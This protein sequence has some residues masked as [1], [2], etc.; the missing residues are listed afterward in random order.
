M[1]ITKH[2]AI[3]HLCYKIAYYKSVGENWADAVNVD[4]LEL[5]VRALANSEQKI[6]SWEMDKEGNCY[7][8]E[9]GLHYD[10]WV[11][12]FKYCPNCGTK[13]EEE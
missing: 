2:D 6:S 13:M 11:R 8:P 10:S 9:C 1:I 7:C 3:K 12:G 4:V 5:A